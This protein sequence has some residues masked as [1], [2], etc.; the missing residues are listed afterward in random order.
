[1]PN[2]YDQFP[3]DGGACAA[4]HPDNLSAIALLFGL[5]PAKVDSCRVLELGCGTGANLLP[6]AAALPGSRFVGVDLSRVQIDGGLAES[7]SLG[8]DN[9]TL[10]TGDLAGLAELGSFDYVIAQGVF[11]WVPRAVQEALLR[12]T[13]ECLAEDGV[14][15]VSYDALP[16]AYPRLAVRDLLAFGARRETAPGKRVEA[17]RRFAALAARRLEDR[18]P[19]SAAIRRLIGELGGMSDAYVLHDYLSEC[20]DASTLTDFASRAD[21]HRLRYMGDAQ[22]HTMFASDAS[23]LPPELGAWAEDQVEAEQ[24]LDFIGQRPFR[25]SLLC[26]AERRVDRKLT[27]ER[28]E[29]LFLTT[30]AEPRGREDE[31]WLFRVPSRELFGTPSPLVAAALQRLI[32][33][34]P[35]P[36]PFSELCDQARASVDGKK[37]ATAEDRKAIGTDLLAAA[38]ASQV[39]LGTWDR[40]LA[41]KIEEKPRAFSFARRQAQRGGTA[42][43][44]LWHRAVPLDP[45]QRA[46]LP[47]LDGRR[48]RA[49]ILS[50]LKKARPETDGPWLEAQLSS[51]EKAAM[52]GRE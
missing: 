39:E 15:Y 52:L 23:G 8:L 48:T 42:A 49:Q 25:T 28:L 27:W 16:G 21:A 20:H 43:V 10:M 33:A 34:R 32:D 7:A 17:A 29:D 26:R 19:N 37:R 50:A 30:Y 11:S 41:T 2:A 4:S 36:L 24:L 6:M 46:V 5:S 51:L 1:M 40:G 45:G 12:V 3:Y 38:A 31:H 22:F 44:N 13:R 14:A 47:L 18:A 9:L 35:R